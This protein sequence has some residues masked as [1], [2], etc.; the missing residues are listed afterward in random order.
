VR[1]LIA[2]LESV[3]GD[4]G[5]NLDRVERVLAD[6]PSA[7]LAILPELFLSGYELAR[8]EELAI[9]PDDAALDRIRAAAARHATA[10]LIRLIERTDDGDAANSAACIDAD[11]R[12]VAM[13]RK[14]HLFGEAERR[15]FTRGE[16]LLIVELAGVRVAPLICFDIEFPEPARALARAGAELLASIAANMDPYGPDHELAAPARALDNR[17][18]HVYVNQVGRYREL[19][20]VGGSRAIGADARLLA[21][22]G[23]HE[24]LIEVDVPLDNSPVRGEVDYLRHVRTD[25]PVR[26]PALTNTPDRGG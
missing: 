15:A 3:P 19:R 18:A 14:T 12:L 13:Y 10:V 8:A 6:H 25:L 26:G 11:G 9:A 5:S 16:E 22:A 23:E 7:E 2:Q 17:R 1:V 21:R 20:F 4:I 24:E